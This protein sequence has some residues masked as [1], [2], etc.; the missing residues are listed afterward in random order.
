MKRCKKCGELKLETIENFNM[1]SSGNYR[2]T[3]KKCMA[4]NT[5]KHYEEN[6]NRVMDRVSKYKKQKEAADGYCSESDAEKIRI[7]Q[8]DR[9]AY[10]HVELNRGGELDHKIPVSRNGNNWPTNMAWACL[11]CNRDKHNKTAEE[12]FK[13]RAE[14]GFPT[15]DI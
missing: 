9:C 13:W 8:E 1:L 6:P 3:C 5:K 12:F 11:T 4:A 15:I 10:C 14:R 2:G 7:S